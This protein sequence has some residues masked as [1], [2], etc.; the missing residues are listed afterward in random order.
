MGNDFAKKYALL[1]KHS[2]CAVVMPPQPCRSYHHVLRLS[3]RMC[4]LVDGC[5]FKEG[6]VCVCHLAPSDAHR[7]VF[8]VSGTVATEKPVSYT[9]LTL[10]TNREV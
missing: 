8:P 3:T 2:T 4:V 5:R 10:P 1:V 9:H 6:S 7:F